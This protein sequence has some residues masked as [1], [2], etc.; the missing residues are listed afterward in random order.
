[1]T[2][3]SAYIFSSHMDCRSVQTRTNNQHKGFAEMQSLYYTVKKKEWLRNSEPFLFTY[4][5]F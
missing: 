3:Q 2:E 4:P 1:M 5:F